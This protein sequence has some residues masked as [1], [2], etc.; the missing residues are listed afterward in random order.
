MTNHG[1]RFGPLPDDVM[2]ALLEASKDIMSDQ[3][4]KDPLVRRVH[5]SYF[6]FKAKHDRWQ[7]NSEQEFQT[8]LR[9]LGTQ[10]NL[11]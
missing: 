9:D 2:R 3:A 10:L 11:S 4:A 6:E 7:Q 1:V 8:R 5:Q